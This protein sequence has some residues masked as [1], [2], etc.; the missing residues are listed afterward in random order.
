MKILLIETEPSGHH[1]SLYLNALVDK[2]ISENHNVSILTSIK[3]KNFPSFSYIKTKNVKIYYLEKYKNFN[4]NGYLNILINQIILYFIIKKKINSIN[5]FDLIYLNTFTVIDKALSIFGSPF[6][7]TKFS[8][9]FPAINFIEKQKIY[10]FSFYKNMIN[11]FLFNKLLNSENL[12]NIFIPDHRFIKY[13]KKKFWH[14]KKINLSYDFGFHEE[15]KNSVIKKKSINKKLSLNLKK[16]NNFVILVY[17]SIRFEKG[18]QFLL[19]AANEIKTKK[20]LTIIIAGKHDNYTKKIVNKYKEN[21]NFSL[22]SIDKFLETEFQR[23]LFKKANLVWTGYTKNYFGSSAVFF[24]SGKYKKPNISSNHGLISKYNKIYKT[25][26]SVE[27]DNI[28]NIKKLLSNI[29]YTNKKIEN[30]YFDILNNIHNSKK[31]SDNIF[32]RLILK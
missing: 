31:F 14:Y 3:T 5:K 6:K 28:K 21:N 15:K 18:I 2:L 30:K 17:G 23:Y 12:I 10:S 26:Y 4:H 7:N 27:I 11:K 22:F 1:I 25:G 8:G 20:N 29:I 32:N 13:S 19:K 24:L 16:K 9:L